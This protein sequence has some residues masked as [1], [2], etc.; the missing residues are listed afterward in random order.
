MEDQI[1]I[2]KIKKEF[3]WDNYHERQIAIRLAYIGWNLHGFTYQDKTNDTVEYYLFEALVKAKLIKDPK[4]CN[5]SLCG[6]TDAG[7]SG[8]GN[9]VSVRVRSICPTGKGAIKKQGAKEQKEEM[10]YAQILN[11]IL[12]EIIR[13]TGIAYV[14]LNFNARFMCNSRGYR[15]FFHLLSMDVDRMREAASFLIGEHDYRAFCKFSPASTSHCVRRIDKIEMGNAGN[16]IWFFEIVGSGFIWHQIRCIAYILFTVGKGLEKPSITQE[17]LDIKK[18]P[19]RPNYH[20]ADP[21]PLVFWKAYF[22][23]VEW[24]ID[25]EIESKVKANF[26]RQLVDMDIKAA[27][28]RCFADGDIPDAIVKKYTPI[29]KLEIGKSVEQIIEEYRKEKNMLPVDNNDE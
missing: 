22:E 25:C 29:S 28:L 10:N 23:G 19:G 6:R 5:Y 24:F 8:V 3:S 16:G 21:E 11:G 14:D 7:V 4:N 18:Y 12:P 2:P 1:A 13:V 17:L 20:I 9:V 27:V 26:A 15:Y